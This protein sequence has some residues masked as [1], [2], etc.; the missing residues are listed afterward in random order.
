LKI[1][2]LY[3][4]NLSGSIPSVLCNTEKILVDCETVECACCICGDQ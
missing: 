4:N 3:G 1:L 2:E